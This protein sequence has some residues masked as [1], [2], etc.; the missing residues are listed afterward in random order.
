MAA[1]PRRLPCDPSGPSPPR[2]GPVALAVAGC[3]NQP[4]QPTPPAPAQLEQAA[5]P[6]TT[7]TRQTPPP[8]RPPAPTT[9]TPKPKPSPAPE[10]ILG[11]WPATTPEQASLLQ[12]GPDAGHQPWLRSPE[13]VSTAY[14][15]AEYGIADPVAHQV[16]PAADQVGADNSEWVATL[17]LAQ[18]VRQGAGGVWVITRTANPA[19][20]S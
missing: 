18:P 17:H 7:P 4:D 16:G 12:D 15:T 11:L 3:Q 13:R 2:P 6:T 8:H 1:P 5:P 9:P 14:A 19:G 20:R 10:T